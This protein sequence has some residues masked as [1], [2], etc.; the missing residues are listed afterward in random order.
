MENEI[1]KN[2]W[3][4]LSLVNFDICEFYVKNGYYSTLQNTRQNHLFQMRTKK[5]MTESC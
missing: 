1:S 5:T 3:R 4:K 2:V